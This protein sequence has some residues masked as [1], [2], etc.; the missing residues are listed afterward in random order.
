MAV[1]LGLAAA[2]I[3]TETDGSI[4]GPAAKNGI[5]GIKPTVGLTS[6]D[7]VIPISEHQD[8]VG[9]MARCVRDAALLLGV[10]AGRDEDDRYTWEMGGVP[11]YVDACRDGL[12]GARLGVPFHLLDREGIEVEI[13]EFKKALGMLEDCGAVVV[14]CEFGASKRDIRGKEF[15]VFAADFVPGL[16]KYL[17][18]LVYNPSGIRTLQDVRDLT[19]QSEQEEYPE[20]NTDRWDEALAQGW[21]NTDV[22]FGK[23]Y[24]E[25][26]D[27]GNACL[28]R[29]LEELELDAV[30]LPTT[31]A[32]VWA[33]VV[34]AP[35]ITVPLGHY[36][37]DAVV[38]MENG[39]V[40]TGP[41]VPFGL[42]FL[43]RRWGEERLIGLAY[44][45]EERMRVRGGE[46]VRV[47]EPM[48]GVLREG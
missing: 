28:P 4:M 2:A 32:P 33:A 36:P 46:V 39:L 31:I 26:M 24:G 27:M 6:R 23:V 43:G 18:Q 37:S 9:P 35:I 5:V 41:G 40:D 19:R 14:E 7:L 48:G 30:V 1:D 20:K 11:D 21:D 10:L 29:V 34:G 12:R 42:S 45:F 16:E 25:L 13:E 8:S 22:E 3:G 15:Q 38:R 17:S 47:I 44:G